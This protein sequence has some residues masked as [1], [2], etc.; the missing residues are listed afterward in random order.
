VAAG[1][2]MAAGGAVVAVTSGSEAGQH[3]PIIT[4]RAGRPAAGRVG[5]SPRPAVAAP[6]EGR[7]PPAP[8]RVEHR[9]RWAPARPTE[10]TR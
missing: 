8:H 1:A 6:P 4:P 9:G 2:M 7:G 3:A 5:R 10:E